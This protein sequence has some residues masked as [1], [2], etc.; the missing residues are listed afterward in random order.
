MSGYGLERRECS[1]TSMSKDREAEDRS[2]SGRNPRYVTE[3]EPPLTRRTR[4]AT[5]LPGSERNPPNDAC[6]CPAS[7]PRNGCRKCK[8]ESSSSVLGVLKKKRGWEGYM[9]QIRAAGSQAQPGTQTRNP[10]GHV[11]LF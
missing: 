10:E 11:R 2:I 6:Q 9:K 4:E 1:S 3:Y 7:R 8:A 5:S